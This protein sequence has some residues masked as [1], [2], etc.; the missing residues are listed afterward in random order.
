MN[1][2]TCIIASG[3]CGV[4]F[5]GFSVCQAADWKLPIQMKAGTA[6]T[7]VTVG[8]AGSATD[9]YDSAFDIPAPA[10][11]EK[12]DAYIP[13]PEWSVAM[14][15]KQ[16]P[17]F[18]QDI[19]SATAQTFEIIVK[20][21]TSP[22]AVSWDSGILPKQTR[23]MM[24]DGSNGALID[25]KTVKNYA[26]M[27]T[28]T[29]KLVVVAEQPDTTS[30]SAPTGVTTA[31]GIR[32][33][34]MQV[35]WAANTESD[36][37]GYRIRMGSVPG[38]WERTVDLKN[39]LNYNLFDLAPVQPKYVALSAYDKS[40]NESDFGGSLEVALPVAS[41]SGVCG[42]SSNGVFTSIPVTGLCASGATLAATGNG[43]PWNWNCVGA[44]SGSSST[45]QAWIKT[46]V[47][48]FSAGSGGT[49]NG[50]LSQ[51]VDH[52]A[53]AATVTAIANS[54]YS[55]SSWSGAANGTMNPFA[56][57][58]VTSDMNITAVFAATPAGTI[59]A[60]GEMDGDGKVTIR[61]A[62]MVI[63]SVVGISTLSSD[64][65]KHADVFPIGAAD[66]EL[67]IQDGIIILRKAL[68]LTY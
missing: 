18:H 40:G 49:I 32:A 6:V 23:V 52:G 37:A 11:A 64:Q 4:L 53:D 5:S 68:G 67:T 24:I 44:G 41:V 27:V 43:H 22:V 61:D 35:T 25:M 2:M 54:G 21:A 9:G 19:R 66:G 58:G 48:T 65:L 26:L 62:L 33:N 12:L 14:G 50:P 28:G 15:G 34:S 46:W 38:Q 31:P 36:L 29:A 45:C 51:T 16:L 63:R 55:F 1:K 47:V 13:H 3:L 57:T 59:E 8:T 7:S 10:D 56:P 17:D 20:S 60:D 42:T 30:P 39:V